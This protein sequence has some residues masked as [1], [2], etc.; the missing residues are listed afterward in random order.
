MAT[1]AWPI[2]YSKNDEYGYGGVAVGKDGA[3]VTIQAEPEPIEIDVLQTAVLVV[4]MQ[5]AFV[6]QG[7]YLNLVGFDSALGGGLPRRVRGQAEYSH[8]F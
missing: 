4:N 1:L 8:L 5:N 3:Y 6:R 2:Y 7:G